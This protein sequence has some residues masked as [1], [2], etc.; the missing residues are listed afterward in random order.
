MGRFILILAMN[1]SEKIGCIKVM[2]GDDFS[3]KS[4]DYFHI[5]MYYRMYSTKGGFADELHWGE[6]LDIEAN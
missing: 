5:K 1:I 3:S 6:L 2:S 4:N